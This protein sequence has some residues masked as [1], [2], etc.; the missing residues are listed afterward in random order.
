MD[1]PQCYS[2]TVQ[3]ARSSGMRRGRCCMQNPRRMV[4]Q[5]EMSGVTLTQQWNEGRDL[6]WELRQRSMKPFYEAPGQ[7]IGLEVTN[8]AAEFS[9]RLW[10]MSVKTSWGS[11]PHPQSERRAC[12]QLNDQRSRSTN[13]SR[14]FPC[15]PR[16]SRY[17][18]TGW[19]LV[20]EPLGMSSLEE[21]V[22]A[23][24]KSSPLEMSDGEG[25]LG[26][27]QTY[28]ARPMEKNWW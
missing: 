1:N 13:H 16:K 24:G 14:P 20:W 10:K 2:C 9:T 6:R 7:I 18:L 5:E 19:H 22:E 3:G 25:R 8:R 15:R 26:R 28:Q 23:I 11:Q 12:T 21:A 4:F 17:T 27:S